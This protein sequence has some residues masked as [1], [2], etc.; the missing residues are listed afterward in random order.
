[1][2]NMSGRWLRVSATTY[3]EGKVLVGFLGDLWPHDL[4]TEEI[5][6][7]KAFFHMTGAR[8]TIYNEWPEDIRPRYEA[9]KTNFKNGYLLIEA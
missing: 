1:M 4:T 3:H 6:H 5:N 9:A 7:I 2:K 8:H